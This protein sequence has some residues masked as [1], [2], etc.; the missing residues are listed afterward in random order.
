MRMLLP[1]YRTRIA[2]RDVLFTHADLPG[3]YR[4]KEVLD[5]HLRW[6]DE[7]M[8]AGTL[9]LG[10]SRAKWAHRRLARMFWDR[11]F[12][13]LASAS[14]TQIA[15]LC[16]KVG[17]DFIVTG[18]TPVVLVDTREREPFPLLENHPNWIGGERRV[19]LKTADYTVASGG[20]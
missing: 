12:S 17:V 5:D 14:Q 1:A 19:A 11:T 8:K 10:G 16:S 9:G 6:I 7:H 4:D 15:A 3:E 13:D 2:G 18:H 20:C